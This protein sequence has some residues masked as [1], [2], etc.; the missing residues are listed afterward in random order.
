MLLIIQAKMTLV[1]Y[2]S[3]CIFIHTKHEWCSLI[4][5]PHRSLESNICILPAWLEKVIL[6]VIISLPQR[7]PEQTPH[8]LTHH[9][10]YSYVRGH[11]HH[12]V[13]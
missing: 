3:P 8:F 2:E 6:Q 4:C 11:F 9:N 7:W 1:L 10:Q 5:E 12:V 13:H